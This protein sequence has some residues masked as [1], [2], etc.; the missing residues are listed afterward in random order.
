MVGFM[1]G[2]KKKATPQ[3]SRLATRFITIFGYIVVIKVIPHFQSRMFPS[4]ERY[5]PSKPGARWCPV[6]PGGS[7]RGAT[8][9]GLKRFANIHRSIATP[10]GGVVVLHS[11]AVRDAFWAATNWIFLRQKQCSQFGKDWNRQEKFEK[12][13]PKTSLWTWHQWSHWIKKHVLAGRVIKF[14]CMTC[15]PSY[16]HRF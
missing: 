13:T 16:D 4:F 7:D 1:S 6:M 8:Q 12:K 5:Q 11:S 9:G 14:R 3:P 15:C 2:F 10:L